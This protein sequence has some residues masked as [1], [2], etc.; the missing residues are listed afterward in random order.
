MAISP[1]TMIFTT[2]RVEVTQG[3]LAL[4]GF[5]LYSFTT[6]ALDLCGR[7][8]L[9]CQIIIFYFVARLAVIGQFYTAF[10]AI[11]LRSGGF[12]RCVSSGECLQ[13]HSRLQSFRGPSIARTQRFAENRNMLC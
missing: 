12:I 10:V 13:I 1:K 9:S 7:K 6:S 2:I 4:M 3:V 8:N 11:T 5:S